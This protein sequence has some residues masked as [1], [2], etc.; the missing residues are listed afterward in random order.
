MAT[1]S[2]LKLLTAVGLPIAAYFG[3]L[4]TEPVKKWLLNRGERRRLRNALYGE[5]A[6]NFVAPVP[7]VIYLIDERNKDLK[8]DNWWLRTEVYAEAMKQP[9]LFYELR[10]SKFISDLYTFISSVKALNADDQHKK[11]GGVIKFI[12]DAV[13]DKRLSRP[14]FHR[15]CKRPTFL[16][17]DSQFEHPFIRRLKRQ[18]RKVAYRNLPSNCGY[19]PPIGVFQIIK[20]LFTGTPPEMLQVAPRPSR[21]PNEPQM[22]TRPPQ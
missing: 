18:Y 20:S 15:H 4:F 11:L 10:E 19:R 12:E 7:N 16:C 9:V 13:Q 22:P 21:P 17:S 3:G 1:D 8:P 14:L 6:V 5:I 2:A